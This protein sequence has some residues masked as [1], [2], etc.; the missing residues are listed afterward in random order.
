MP[1]ARCTRGLACNGVEEA[2]TS[3]QVQ[4]RHSGI[5]CAMALRLIR[6]LPGDEF[7]FCHRRQRI[8]ICQNPVGPTRLRWLD[9]SHGCQNHT[10]SP[11]AAPS[12]VPPTSEMPTKVVAKALKRRSSAQTLDHS[13]ENPP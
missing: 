12:P 13:R 11:Y 10:T 7:P 6:A 8:E 5:P 9:I 1:D 2:H 3:I 4:R